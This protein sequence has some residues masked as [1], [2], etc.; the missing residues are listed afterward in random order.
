MTKKMTAL[1]VSL[2]MVLTVLASVVPASAY[3]VAGPVEI[4][5]EIITPNDTAK[6]YYGTTI[7]WNASN[8]AGFYYDLDDD[9]GSENLTIQNGNAN[10]NSTNLSQPANRTITEKD[11][12]YQTQAE[13]KEFEYKSFGNYSVIGFLAEPYFTGYDATDAGL[14]TVALNGLANIVLSNTKENTS[15]N[16]LNLLSGDDLSKVL[17]DS[18][19]KFTIATGD[20]LDL[21]EGYVLNIQQVDLEGNKALF[22]LTKDGKVVD[23]EVVYP[24]T[25]ADVYVYDELDLGDD[26]N[27][28]TIIA[29][30]DTVFRGTDTNVVTIEGLFQI[31][32][33]LT[34]VESGDTYGDLE[35]VGAAN[36]HSIKMNNKDTDITLSRDSIKNIGGNVKFKVADST[37]L[38]FYP[39]A[40]FSEP[41]TYE[42][43]GQVRRTNGAFEWNASNFAAFFYDIDDDIGSENL[44]VT[45]LSTREIGEKGLVYQTQAEAKEFEYKS[46]GNYSVVGFLAEPYFTGYDATDAGLKTVA[47]NGL[48]NIVLSNTKENTSLNTLNLLSGDDLSKVLIDS[49][50]KFTIA[51]GDGLDLKEGYVLNIQQVDLEGNKALFELTK[52]GKVVDTEVVYPQTTADVYVYDELDLGDDDNVPTIIARVDTVFRGTDTNVVTIEGLFQISDTLTTVESGDTY[53]D[54]EVVGAANDH[55]I[56]MNNKDTNVTLSRDSVK[57]LSDTV[58]FR[59]ADEGTLRYY[60]FV[61]VTIE[62]EEVVEEEE[63]VDVDVDEPAVNVTDADADAD[64]DVDADADAVVDEPAVVTPDEDDEE[65]EVE[66][67]EEPGFEAV[68]AIT[69]LLAV[70]FL[71]LRQRE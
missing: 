24:Q 29:R 62:G 21:K 47:L 7:L 23:T 58:Q 41:G 54:L 8:F 59:V 50:D 2:L 69:G 1:A 42:I 45:F 28:P 52:D 51:T 17:I 15:L 20:G 46:F 61:E 25:T 39:F 27:V 5:G 68:F 57:K 35:V 12:V 65:D 36:D 9:I 33:T 48:A 56:K 11:L 31:S 38:R 67:E 22:E 40:E 66:P 49:D 18:D 64:A 70:A 43:R 63:P 30:V 34:T 13:A 3:T 6:T 14:K 4:R 10:A 19:D 55:S 26:D 44:T 53:G 37:T 16:T 60:P 71:V 32:D